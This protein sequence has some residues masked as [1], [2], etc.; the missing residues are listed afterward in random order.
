MSGR[1]QEEARQFPFNPV[2]RAILNGLVL[3]VDLVNLSILLAV[4][5]VGK[6]RTVNIVMDQLPIACWLVLQAA[7]LEWIFH[8]LNQVI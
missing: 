3:F 6:M 1:C 5:A 2:A 7:C 4:T 8:N